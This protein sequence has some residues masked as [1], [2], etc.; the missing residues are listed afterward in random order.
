[1]PGLDGVAALGAFRKLV[2]RW[3][4]REDL[5]S[6]MLAG[7]PGASGRMAEDDAWRVGVLMEIDG[8]MRAILPD[9]GAWLVAPNP[10]PLL[11]GRSPLDFL[12]RT[13]TPGY[14]SLLRQVRRW[15]E[16]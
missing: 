4:V 2:A 8:A 10:G 6:T 13:G 16:M 1:M 11:M 9:V 12:A 15:T 5:A 14:V 7:R 3:G